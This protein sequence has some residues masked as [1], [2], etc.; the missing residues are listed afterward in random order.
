MAKVTYLGDESAT[1]D[2]SEARSVEWGG[3]VF[4]IGKAVE[5]D[6]DH[7]DPRIYEKMKTNRFFKV[8]EGAKPHAEKAS[9]PGI[10]PKPE[11]VKHEPQPAPSPAKHEPPK[12]PNNPFK[13]P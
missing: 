13:G 7:F 8:E 4:E 2:R 5:I 1:A 11:A 10:Q 3:V 12:A 6:E 9:S